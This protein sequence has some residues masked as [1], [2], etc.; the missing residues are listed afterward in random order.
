MGGEAETMTRIIAA[1]IETSDGLKGQ[2]FALGGI[3][4]G[5]RFYQTDNLQDYLNT[6][7]SFCG[8][9]FN[10]YFHNLNFDG[11]FILQFCEEHDIPYNLIFRDS[12]LLCIKIRKGKR[13]L[14]ILNSFAIIPK[15]LA[16][17]TK[18]FNLQLEKPGLDNLALRNKLDCIILYEGLNRFFAAT[19]KGMT[20]SQIALKLYAKQSNRKGIFQAGELENIGRFGYFGGRVEV[21]NFNPQRVKIY[22]INSLYP[23]VM[24]NNLYPINM[25]VEKPNLDVLDKELYYVKAVVNIEEQFIPPLP[26][27][28]NN[29][30]IFPTGTIEGWFYSPELNL[31]KDNVIEIKE[32]YSF[33]GDYLFKD[34]VNHYWRLRKELKEQGNGLESVY[35]LI[36]NSLYGKFAQ[37]REKE[38]LIRQEEPTEGCVELFE[39]IYFKTALVESKSK[40]IN[41]F[42]SGFITSYARAYLYKFLAQD[43]AYC[44]TDSVFIASNRHLPVGSELGEFKLEAEGLFYPL[45]P[46]VYYL[47]ND[48]KPIAKAKG[49]SRLLLKNVKSYQEFFD[50][51]RNNEIEIY[52]QPK[53]AIRRTGN[54]LSVKTIKKQFTLLYDKRVKLADLTTRPWDMSELMEIEYNKN[55]AKYRREEEKYLR[56][57]YKEWRKSDYFD[58]QLIDNTLTANENYELYKLRRFGDFYY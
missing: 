33:E 15:P 19:A 40:W 27:K 36:L 57:Q 48:K 1:D 54:Y 42:I 53:E 28:F 46:K 34:F 5:K 25:K 18:M 44:D 6:L 45:A 41:P 14:K 8:K 3:Y 9:N 47:A 21:F 24:R 16:D 32:A 22:D 29:K 56:E 52:M 30:L 26:I 20:V 23:T 37:K 31:V 12:M 35:K 38:T 7:F 49:L 11:R 51:I 13:A 2:K 17:F 10:V 43:V 58:E 4:T 50:L 39:G 55:M